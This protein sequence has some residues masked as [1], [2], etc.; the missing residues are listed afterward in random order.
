MFAKMQSFGEVFQSYVCSESMLTFD[1]SR[2]QVSHNV[3]E[4]ILTYRAFSTADLFNEGNCRIQ[5]L[6]ARYMLSASQVGGAGSRT[7]G[8][9]VASLQSMCNNDLPGVH[10]IVFRDVDAAEVEFQQASYCRPSS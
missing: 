6:A 3:A 5:G 7:P 4:D 9:P 1:E 2:I 10:S 8:W